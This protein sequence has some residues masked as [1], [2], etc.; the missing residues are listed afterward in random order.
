MPDIRVNNRIDVKGELTF[1]IN[2]DNTIEGQFITHGYH[3]LIQ[4]LESNRYLLTDIEV[5]QEKFDA[6]DYNIV[7]LFTA[8]NRIIKGGITNL[9]IDIIHR[10]DNEVYQDDYD[11]LIKRYEKEGKE[12]G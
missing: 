6:N 7:Y 9:D 8:K 4:S 1:V 10:I 2:S 3:E 5:Y 11:E 12:L